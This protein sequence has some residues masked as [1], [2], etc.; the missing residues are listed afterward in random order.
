MAQSLFLRARR[1]Y[2]RDLLSLY[3]DGE[4]APPEADEGLPCLLRPPLPDQPQ[5]GLGKELAQDQEQDGRKGRQ[6]DEVLEGH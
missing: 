2:C 5:R 3:L 1:A 4:A 6:L